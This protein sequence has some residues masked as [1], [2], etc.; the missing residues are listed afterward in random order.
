MESWTASST[1]FITYDPSVRWA[2]FICVAG[3]AA[4]VCNN[5][6]TK[7][8]NSGFWLHSLVT[9]I[10][11]GFGGGIV[12]P[13]L[14]GI[15]PAPLLRDSIILI[16]CVVWWLF[17]HT[18][19]HVHKFYN[20]PGVRHFGIILEEIFRANLVVVWTTKAIPITSESVCGPILVGTIA[21]VGGMFM[22]WNKGL[23]PL[24][25]GSNWNVE[26]SFIAA[27]VVR[28]LVHTDYFPS[29]TYE[30]RF[31]TISV[32]VVFVVVA[33]IRHHK[34]EFNPTEPVNKCASPP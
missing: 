22:P 20:L 31:M 28:F 26:S 34:P 2:F 16:M 6:F 5:I 15:P 3:R 32:F 11:C 33:L 10:L 30:Q 7:N 1:N 12:A 17:F 13:V 14:M 23:A 25:A 19:G 18:G 24:E 29:C 9:S 4:H 21:G 27:I 8:A